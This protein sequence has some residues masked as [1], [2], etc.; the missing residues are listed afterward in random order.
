MSQ[1]LR[2]FVVMGGLVLL[3]WFAATYSTSSGQNQ[4]PVRAPRWEYHVA[5]DDVV[6]LKRVNELG[7]DGWELVTVLVKD[8]GRPYLAIYKRPLQ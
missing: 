2:S 8:S 3:G 7:H 4:A 6:E 5:H 1:N